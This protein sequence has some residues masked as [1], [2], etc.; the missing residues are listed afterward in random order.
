MAKAPDILKIATWIA[1]LILTGLTTL[2]A[3]D[4]ENKLYYYGIT[5]AIIPAVVL[6]VWVYNLL[7]KNYLKVL[8]DNTKAVNRTNELREELAAQQ[9]QMIEKQKESINEEE[10]RYGLVSAI[11][12]SVDQVAELVKTNNSRVEYAIEIVNGNAKETKKTLAGFN[13]RLI[14][15][16][17]KVEKIP[18]LERRVSEIEN[19]I[20]NK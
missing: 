1:G 16:E 9:M 5:I 12:R 7:Q 11:R 15:M 13:D 14:S 17:G 6:I 2:M 10:K 18:E 19:K 3:L 4:V 20:K 8:E